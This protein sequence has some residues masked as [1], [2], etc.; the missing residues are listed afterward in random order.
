VQLAALESLL[1]TLAIAVGLAAVHVL[2]S[3]IGGFLGRSADATDSVAGG[4][5]TAYVFLNVLPRLAE[6]N[7]AVAR[8]LDDV[9]DQTPLVQLAVF[10]VALFGFVTFYLLERLAREHRHS[11]ERIR[12][13]VFV[14]Y[15]GAFSLYSAL[16]VY[17]IPLKLRSGLMVGLLFSVVIALHLVMTD[18]VLREHFPH[19]HAGLGRPLLA[20]G[21]L[22]GWAAAVVAG[23]RSTL[24]VSVIS[25]F[26]AGAIL[27]NVLNDELR[28]D[29]HTSL[30]WFAAGL[31]L[32]TALLTLVIALGQGRPA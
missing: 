20:A 8:Q 7:D 28:I 2:G 12:A 32:N 1:V 29:R 19:H 25:A 13:I 26:L 15:V 18:R 4:L 30:G 22:A 21:P 6:G 10:F 3:R 9:L 14:P 16:I 31:A 17:T 5:A 23:P 11:S 24:L 27:L